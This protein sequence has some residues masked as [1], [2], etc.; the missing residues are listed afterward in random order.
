MFLPAQQYPQHKPVT[1]SCEGQH[2]SQ[3]ADLSSGQGLVPHSWRGHRL[4]RRPCGGPCYVLWWKEPKK[5]PCAP[6]TAAEIEEGTGYVWW[7]FKPQDGT[8]RLT[9]ILFPGAH[10]HACDLK[11][12]G[13]TEWDVNRIRLIAHWFELVWQTVLNQFNEIDWRFRSNLFH[14]VGYFYSSF[15]RVLQ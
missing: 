11:K 15:T 13:Q 4:H 8:I 2:Q 6:I 12:E 5:S 14:F 7:P 3:H 10:D 1:Q 9:Q